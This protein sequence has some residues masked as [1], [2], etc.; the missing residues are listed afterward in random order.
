MRTLTCTQT[1]QPIS[2]V[3]PVANS[4]EADIWRTD[5]PGT[6]AKIYYSP[7]PERIQKLEVMI[8][9]PPRDPNAHINHI[10]FAWP[11]SILQEPDGTPVGFLMPEVAQAVELLDV[12][13]P[14]RRQKIMPEFNWLYLHATAMNIASLVWAI[15]L[16]DYVLGDLKPQNILVNNGA[17]PSIIDT[18]SFQVRH[19]NTG[20]LYRCPVGSEGFTPPE[21]LGQDL[22]TVEQTEIHDRFRLAVMIYLLLCGDHPFKG[23]WIGP[24]DSPD[25]N[26]LLQNG[27]WPY[28]P[29]SPIQPSALTTPLNVLHPDIQSCFLR[30]FNA[31]HLNPT[32]RPTASEWV[33]VLQGSIAQLKR[34]R[35]VKTHYYSKT[36]GKCYWC[37]RKNSLGVDIFPAVSTITKNPILKT[38]QR[39][40][41]K[42]NLS[43]QSATQTLKIPISKTSSTTSQ[44]LSRWQLRLQ[45]PSVTPP[46]PSYPPQPKSV[47]QTVPL[48]IKVAYTPLQWIQNRWVKLAGGAGL[49]V[50][51]FAGLVWLSQSELEPEDIGLTLVGGGFCL[52]LVVFCIVL[53]NLTTKTPD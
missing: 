39:M 14:L 32:A 28:A 27:W 50:S 26:E 35:K 46:T 13:S 7:K 18:D 37:A 48:P 12:Y 15:H 47:V 30:C 11:T 52:G 9:H 24:G 6:L 3:Q 25:P 10:S 23:R 2:L 17:L 51:I 34:C 8:A 21:L 19:P 49:L 22:A 38:A 43:L 42:A 1:G 41:A 44:A 40:Q 29:N 5:R 16:A 20:M 45:K 4:G 53:I 36:Y 33:K 31:G